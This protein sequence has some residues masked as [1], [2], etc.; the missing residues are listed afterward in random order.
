[1]IGVTR[2]DEHITSLVKQDFPLVFVG[3]RQIGDNLPVHC[4]TFDYKPAVEAIVSYLDEKQIVYVSSK[5]SLAEP[6]ADKSL[7]LHDFCN[8]NGIAVVDI[9]IE[10]EPCEE[11]MKRVLSSRAVIFDRLFIADLFSPVLPDRGIKCAIFEDDWTET[12]STWTRWENRRL[13]LGA[14][15]AKHLIAML[16]GN[17]ELG[18]SSVS[19]PLIIPDSF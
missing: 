8:R 19:I 5:H 13:E 12:H 10:D 4:V 2:D 6:S 16:G 14:L 11:D 15:A 18:E 17:E 9:V 7:F 3:R 1:M